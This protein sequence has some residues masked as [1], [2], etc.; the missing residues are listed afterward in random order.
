MN[1]IREDWWATPVWFFDIPIEEVNH[2]KIVDECYLQKNQSEGRICSN[3]HG[4]QSDDIFTNPKIPNIS[5]LIET[6]QTHS[7]NIFQD[8]GVKKEINLVIANS[9]ININS[10]GSYN[11]PHIHPTPGLSGVYYA[12][13]PK[14]S[15]NILFHNNS[16]MQF[17]NGI[18]LD[19]T[20]ENKNTHDNIKY[21]PFTGRVI[22]FPS[23]LPHSVEINNSN[24]D[25][26]SI[27]FNFKSK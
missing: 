9:W 17:I 13:A 3:M 8:Y 22:I 12:N 6:I 24:E 4:W 15:G 14:N 19:T 20:I 18:Y 5:N 23:W 16:M 21:E 27:A 2:D 25:R 11:A 7:K 1:I 10:P 26:I